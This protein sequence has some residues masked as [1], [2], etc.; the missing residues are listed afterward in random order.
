MLPHIRQARAD[1]E[2]KNNA[3]IEAVREKIIDD[4][5]KW[6]SKYLRYLD[7]EIENLKILLDKSKDVPIKT[8]RDRAAISQSFQKSLSLILDFVKPETS[9]N[10]T[11]INIDLSRLTEKEL[12][13]YGRLASKLEGIP[14]GEGTPPSS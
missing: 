6:A 7:E 9:Q 4:A 1:R 12:E 14:E 3:K 11:N 5:D 13:D 8:A 10:I 2:A